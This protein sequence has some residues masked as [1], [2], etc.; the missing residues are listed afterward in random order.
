MNDFFEGRSADIRIVQGF[1]NAFIRRINLMLVLA[2]LITSAVMGLVAWLDENRA[3]AADTKINFDCRMVDLIQPME[4]T[5]IIEPVEFID[6]KEL[7]AELLREEKIFLRQEKI[8]WGE[9]SLPNQPAIAA[10]KET[11]DPILAG[12][13]F[14]SSQEIVNIYVDFIQ[15]DNP[16][17]LDAKANKWAT[18]FEQWERHYSFPRG[19][20]VAIAHKESWHNPNAKSCADAYGLMQVQYATGQEVAKR[21]GLWSEPKFDKPAKNKKEAQERIRQVKKFR[22]KLINILKNPEYNIR[23]GAFVLHRFLIQE[24]GNWPK[25]LAR[26]SGGAKN[27]E[28]KVKEFHAIV[29]KR[30]ETRAKEAASNSGVLLANLPS[31]LPTSKT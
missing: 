22:E 10:V 4:W 16:L 9:N 1:I 18:M 17:V 2:F 15:Q 31:P 5:A 26:Y 21:F 27:Y 28:R 12:L 20:L 14:L 7:D 29:W 23:M 13:E 30:I 3:L 8:S 19:I 11:A 24:K 6:D 25:T